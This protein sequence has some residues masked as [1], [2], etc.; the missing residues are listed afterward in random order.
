MKRFLWSF[1]IISVLAVAGWSAT[2]NS[3]NPPTFL[4][5]DVCT[6]GIGENEN[7]MPFP[8][9]DPETVDVGVDLGADGTV[10]RW[11]SGETTEYL[12][13][14]NAFVIAPGNWRR[15]L[16]RLDADAGKQAKVR[17]V[18]NSTDFYIAVK[19]IRLN[20][21]DGVVV[22]N[23]VPNG[24]FEDATP[25][26]GWTILEG[27]ITDASQL[28]VKDEVG[29][30][31]FYGT[32]FYSTM[33]NGNEDTATIETDTFTLEPPTSFVYGMVSGGGSELWNIPEWEGSD[34]ASYVYLDI[35]TDT[36]DPNGQY[37]E[38][39]DVPLTGFYGG[40]STS[41][42]NQI[43]PVFL[44]TSGLEGKRAQ[45]VAVDNSEWYHIGMDAWRMNWAPDHIPNGGFDEEIP[46]DWLAGGPFEYTEH[47][48]GGIPGWEVILADPPDGLAYFFDQACHQGQFNGRSFVGTAGTGDADRIYTGV[49]LRSSV[50]VIEPIPD[51]SQSVFLQFASAQG[52][53]VIRGLDVL[54]AIE[55]QVDV[56]GNGQFD[57][58][59]DFTYTQR[60]QGMG[61]NLNTSNMDLWHYPEYRFYIA[62]EHQGKQARIYC[63]DTLPSNY[64]WLCV[65]DVFVWDGSEARL[66]FPNSDFEVG[67]L[68][69]WT[70]EVGGPLNTWLSGSYEAFMDGRVEHM[71]LN[72]RKTSVDGD[73]AADTAN[74]ATGGGDPGTGTLTSI[75]FTLPTLEVVSV[76]NWSLF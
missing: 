27:S 42:R 73:F 64:G 36:E 44:N 26:S 55:L 18:D 10:D 70:E 29:E 65:D 6:N 50:F 63:I 20:Y 43:H 40:T 34:N 16:I 71:A 56:N 25:L 3:G 57:D 17:I 1:G 66:A 15:Y 69:N 30:Q 35:G 7:G 13:R 41:V 58:A 51:A 22:P 37:D 8:W 45:V 49:E 14:D 24:F 75:A 68:T 60:N 54:G 21:A 62:L 46:D 28:I 9:M 74:N 4:W 47:P 39:T 33:V 59:A 72:D 12:G 19:A 48:S 61:W 2:N 52:T 38:G 76:E 67:D 32:Q 31:I 23:L 53:N 5:L 11:L